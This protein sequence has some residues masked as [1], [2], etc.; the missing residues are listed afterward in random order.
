MAGVA[1][2]ERSGHWFRKLDR[3]AVSQA[4]A[5]TA[6]KRRSRR[7]SSQRIDRPCSLQRWIAETLTDS[8]ILAVVPRQRVCRRYD[9]YRADDA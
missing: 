6:P 7:N 8:R 5:A 2:T 9:L 3:K 1:E 4:L